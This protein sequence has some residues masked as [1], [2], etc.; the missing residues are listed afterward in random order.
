MNRFAVTLAVS[1]SLSLSVSL[2]AVGSDREKYT[3]HT[4]GSSCLLRMMEHG[5]KSET[6]KL[7]QGKT[8]RREKL[9]LGF[10]I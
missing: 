4:V 2:V 6:H 1:V 7:I 8:R 9:M 5:L 3:T 10:V